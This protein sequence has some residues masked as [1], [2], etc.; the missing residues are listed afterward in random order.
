LALVDPG[1]VGVR[2][3]RRS[4]RIPSAGLSR[5]VGLSMERMATAV[6]SRRSWNSRA[7]GVKAKAHP[8]CRRG[9]QH[10]VSRSTMAWCPAPARMAFR[11]WPRRVSWHRFLRP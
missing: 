7:I 2:G 10:S 3:Q 8:V 1:P 11:M 6:I 5:R 4:Q 9:G